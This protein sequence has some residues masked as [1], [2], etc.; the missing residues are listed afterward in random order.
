VATL[1]GVDGGGE[2]Q[3]QTCLSPGRGHF[4]QVFEINIVAAAG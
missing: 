1:F 4:L 3:N 2:S